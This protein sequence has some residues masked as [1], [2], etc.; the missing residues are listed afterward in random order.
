MRTEI[1]AVE[2]AVPAALRPGVEAALDDVRSAGRVVGTLTLVDGEG[3]SCVARDAV[4][5]PPE[6]KA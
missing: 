4:L 5:A 3:E 1:T 6:P 2:L